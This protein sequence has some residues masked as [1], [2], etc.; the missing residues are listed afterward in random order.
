M[1]DMSS[2]AHEM[3][4]QPDLWRRAI[5][6]AA[7]HA[8][9][10][11]AKGARVAVIGCGT[12]LYMAQAV[13]AYREAQHQGETDAFPASEMP[14]G[15]PY[16]L[17]VAISRSGTTTEVLD[18]VKALPPG[19]SVLA[20]TTEEGNPL[21]QLT[22]RR[23]LL[24]WAEER[25][26]VQT[27]FAT[28]ALAVF[29]SHCGWDVAASAERAEEFLKAPSPA[30]MEDV[31]QFVFLGRGVGAAIANEAALKMREILA[32]WAE[33]YP[34]REFRHGPISVLGPG[35]MVW[36]VDDKEPSIDAAIEK[37][38]ACLVRGK[39]DPLAELVR[40]QKAAGELA[41]LRDINPDTPRFLAR[42]IVLEGV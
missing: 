1:L 29:L 18:A 40:A 5:E 23:V 39:G 8:E 22:A 15:R 35:S 41:E 25:S 24:P 7:S 4:T 31:R 27:R 36:V 11:P 20:V 6:T 17:V 19:A 2:Y 30:H 3:G 12:S 28:T 38:G 14:A 32:T 10:L 33:A 42:S 16:D 26:V 21:A 9:L 13:A 37:T 34:T